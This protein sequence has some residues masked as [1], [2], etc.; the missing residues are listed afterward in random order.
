MRDL[1]KV[2]EG[3]LVTERSTVMREKENKYFLKVH[4]RATK[5]E[6]KKAVEQMFKVKVVGVNTMLVGGKTRR[7]GRNIGKK[8]DWKK[9]IVTLKT[10]DSIKFFEGA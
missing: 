8:P 10:G 6:V 3:P 2:I 9:A 4:P 7:V 1:A 5:S